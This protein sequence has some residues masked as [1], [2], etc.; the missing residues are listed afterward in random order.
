MFLGAFKSQ[1]FVMVLTTVLLDEMKLI[2]VKNFKNWTA[3]IFV[4]TNYFLNLEM[5]GYV[6]GSDLNSSREMHDDAIIKDVSQRVVRFENESYL[7][8]L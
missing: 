6:L 8:R 2:V 1:I 4:L 3:Y 7:Q 5:K